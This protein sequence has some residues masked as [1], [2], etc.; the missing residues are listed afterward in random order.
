MQPAPR[1]PAGFARDL[2]AFDGYLNLVWS[3]DLK[4]GVGDPGMMRGLAAARARVIRKEC[5][6]PHWI[7]VREVPEADRLRMVKSGAIE[8]D[9]KFV[10]VLHWQGREDGVGN[11]TLEVNG[12]YLPLDDRFLKQLCGDPLGRW[13]PRTFEEFKQARDEANLRDAIRRRYE[14]EELDGENVDLILTEGTRG[15]RH[16]TA[17]K[18]ENREDGER[19]S[20]SEGGDE[21]A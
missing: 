10:F 14:D 5:E 19:S 16:E 8:P 13:V 9:E 11:I 7:V 12:G 6:I 1:I 4:R 2:R 3:E 20:N 17:T 18:P 21:G 15:A